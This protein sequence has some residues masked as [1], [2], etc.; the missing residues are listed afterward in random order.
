MTPPPPPEAKPDPIDP[1]IL[2]III[3][4]TLD[5]IPHHP[6]AP[7]D[8][9]ATL[10]EAVYTI[11]STLG[12]RD[13]MQAMLAARIAA[14]HF[15]LIDSL[16]CAA[17]NDLPPAIQ[18]RYRASAAAM[19]RMQRAAQN[20]LYHRQASPPLHPKALPVKMT[21][22]AAKPAAAPPP[23]AP[24]T[25]IPEMPVHGAQIQATPDTQPA[26]AK[27]PHAALPRL[28]TA[29]AIPP[30]PNIDKV[31]A[32]AHALLAELAQPPADL[33]ER[34]QAGAAARAAATTA[35]AAAA[36]TALAA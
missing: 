33:G 31:M 5:A 26:P 8:E 25:A 1:T 7:P 14:A 32:K 19:S 28:A 13:V 21:T 6:S 29:T 24:P 23:P 11:I 2:A 36:T 27:H 10:Q 34:L 35:L 18:L 16:R 15:H 4:G 17:L 12:P 20:E 22:T 30:D 3:R 9:I